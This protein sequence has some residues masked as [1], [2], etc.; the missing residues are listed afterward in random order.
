[1]AS[2]LSSGCMETIDLDDEKEEGE[3]SLED[4][5]S[6][7]EGGMGHLTS[8]YVVQNRRRA[9]PD[10][11]SWGEC[12]S[13]CVTYH[14]KSQSRRDPVKG[15]ENRHQ[16]REIGCATAKHTA[17][18]LQEK[19]DDDDLV[20]IS[21]DSDMEIVGLTGT[22]NR[23]RAKVKKKK[24]KKKDYEALTIDE[25]ISPSSVDLPIK[26][27]VKDT[28]KIYREVNPLHRSSGRSKVI[29]KSPIRRYK[30]PPIAR[31]S[32]RSSPPHNHSKSPILKRSPRKVR[33]PKRSLRRHSPVRVTK[34]P[35]KS[36]SPPSS[37]RPY[38]DRHGDVT[39]LLKK[40]KL[41]MDSISPHASESSANRGKES[42]SLKKKLS[43]MLK[44]PVSNEHARHLKRKTKVQ[45]ETVNDA[46]DED[47][48]ALLRQKALET[49]Q[50]KSSNRSSNQP[51]NLEPEKKLT[52]VNNDDQDEEALELRMIALQT[53]F[54]K[55]HE[56]RVRRGKMPT[57]TKKSIRSESPFTTS[58]LDDIPVP[59]DE[60]QLNV[61]SS[62]ICSP[63]RDSN[64]IEDM[65]LD[66]DV[67]REKEKLPYSP[68]DK[69]TENVPIDTALLGIEP[70][71]VSFINV[72]ETI[73]S[74]VFDDVP[75]A[76][77][78]TSY[79]DDA[80][81]SYQGLPGT[82]QYYEYSPSQQYSGETFHSDL[83]RKALENSHGN[84]VVCDLIDGICCQE[85]TYSSTTIMPDNSHA[86]PGSKNLASSPILLDNTFVPS[87]QIV[88]QLSNNS[89]IDTDSTFRNDTSAYKVQRDSRY[90]ITDAPTAIAY[91]GGHVEPMLPIT[92][93]DLSKN[94]TDS[95]SCL[96]DD[97]RNLPATE[98]SREPLYMQNVPDVT[99]DANKIPTLINRTLVPVPI[100]KS[101]K[102]L[103]Q[104]LNKRETPH[105]AEPA[106]K[107]AA[108]QP[109]AVTTVNIGSSSV[110]KPIKLQVA[111]KSTLML[112][113]PTTFDS[114]TNESLDI[115]EDQRNLLEKNHKAVEPAKHPDIVDAANN[116][117]A[118]AQSKKRKSVKKNGRKSLDTAPRLLDNEKS[119]CSDINVNRDTN[120][121]DMSTLDQQTAT[122]SDQSKSNDNTDVQEN[123]IKTKELSILQNTTDTQ[124]SVNSDPVTIEKRDVE[125]NSHATSAE[126]LQQEEQIEF[127]CLS[128]NP[129]PENFNPGAGD[130]TNV[131][132]TN[133]R[134]QSIEEDEDELRAILLASLKRTKSTASDTISPSIAPVV[135]NSAATNIQT[136]ALSDTTIPSVAPVVAN[137]ATTNVQTPPLKAMASTVASMA[138]ATGTASNNA[139]LLPSKPSL[140]SSETVKKKINNLCISVQNTRKRSSS[141]D[142]AKS[143]PKKIPKKALTSTKVVNNAKKYQNM[144]VQRRLNLRKLDNS[145]KSNVSPTSK[146]SSSDTQ[147]FVISLGSDSTDSE[148]EAER[149]QPIPIVEKQ[150]MS[151]DTST[152]FEKNLS[153][154]LREVRTEQ[155]QSAAAAKSS[156]SQATKRDVPQTNNGSS[157]MHTPLAVRHLPASQQE[158]YRRL[159]R[160]ILEREKLKLQ[161]KVASSNNGSSSSS[162]SSSSSNN[163]NK[164][165]NTNVATSPVKSLP[166][167][168]KKAHVK[169]NQGK[170]K[171]PEKNSQELS[172]EVER[173][174]DDT[175]EDTSESNDTS[176]DKKLLMN[177]K[178]TTPTH[179][180]AKNS[181]KAI[182]NDLSIRITNVSSLSHGDRTV[183]N[184]HETQS[185]KEQHRP[186]LRTLSTDE[187]N[188]KY[189]QVVLKTDTIERVVIINDK[190]VSQHDTIAS[191]SQ[192]DNLVEPNVSTEILNETNNVNNDISNISDFSN[193]STVKLKNSA[194]LRV[195]QHE[196]MMETTMTLSQYKAERQREINR[197]ILITSIESNDNSNDS[198][199]S[200]SI[201][202]GNG[203]D[204]WDALKRDVKA[205]LDSLASLSEVERQRYLRETEHKL[206]ARR[207]TVLD[208]LAEMSGNL[209]KWDME[210]DVQSALAN[211]VRKLKEQ[212]KVAEEKLQ[213]QRD[214]ISSM[215]PKVSVVRQ[216]IKTGRHECFKLSRICSTLGN[217]LMG[218]SYKLPE[219][220]AQ[221][222]SDKLK[223]VANHTRQFTKKKR[224]QTI[225]ISENSY[226]SLNSSSLQETSELSKNTSTEEISS[227]QQQSMND[228]AVINK[229]RSKSDISCAQSN[230]DKSSCTMPET[231]LNFSQ[232]VS[233]QLTQE[234][235]EK[236]S[237]SILEHC[238][239]EQVMPFNQNN[240]SSSKP[241]QY[242]SNSI[243][244]NKHREGNETNESDLAAFSKLESSKTGTLNQEYNEQNNRK[245]ALQLQSPSS[246]PLPLSLPSSSPL[247]TTTTTTTTT[248][249]M[250]TKTAVAPYVSILMH[251]KNPRNINPHGILCPY[252][253]MGICRDE[254]CQYIHQSRNQT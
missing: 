19:N 91:I 48:L 223:E 164:L 31:P 163:N 88:E 52:V 153:K 103:Q 63:S 35:L 171:T 148:S 42:S 215:G 251:L 70:S 178:C 125:R 203:N 71:D 224:L 177:S 244:Q 60:Q 80:Y 102:Q 75:D 37:T 61:A 218:K 154:F 5:S 25:L 108:M 217:Q 128:T 77:S 119:L 118:P 187:I 21:S 132:S 83:N 144:I 172:T 236:T 124:E 97:N 134:R 115:D 33:S 190:S 2:D 158:E 50:K 15:K 56:N 185:T 248:T 89:T 238:N 29:S 202:D 176:T 20:P 227:L 173:K 90:S 216:K 129:I 76:N 45:V 26:E 22:S 79:C 113:A 254:D 9:C 209:R 59:D 68:T 49:K 93:D 67:E 95:L 107:S 186:A 207:Y 169:Q 62:P 74:P 159:K 147:R 179:Q 145:A 157:N 162:S 141:V 38:V 10:C 72:N 14:P 106:F 249:T 174:S 146:I 237:A 235:R 197:D 253:M 1:M 85:G 3:I 104:Y 196:D 204:I 100:L 149:N 245:A 122:K 84:G 151:Q 192:N 6:S 12:A 54:T 86:L 250:T 201:A 233:Y 32:C 98:T 17:T 69:I 92:T 53:A 198:R 160:E 212:L 30:S 184:S 166:L 189:V 18:T 65:D 81:L 194:N 246:S 127:H 28:L 242:Q 36:T 46:D 156:S 137:S 183:E 131:T 64:H 40:V 210:K 96:T 55:N 165:L 135:V 43:N 66:T 94:D 39:R 109:V 44:R 231:L 182:P 27:F 117:A 206:V 82:S 221:L 57:K 168:E 152:D 226:S 180:Q 167:C 195:N 188:R 142:A 234:K 240:T 200:D 213:Q 133:N 193:A 121:V 58:Y 219:A 123:L 252:E 16:V 78:V 87:Q 229:A 99:K 136:P 34:R 140:I 225:D 170:I 138:N 143:L 105:P 116:K 175:A 155:E 41:S 47:D 110:F 181:K 7:E 24:R 4:V 101:N 111:K 126:Y 241:K 23:S 161:R 191:V 139:P 150:Q 112:S 211:E 120:I 220:V 205:E 208:H 243:E 214:V 114:S 51:T 199:K 130:S 232:T 13:W 230:Q 239:E 228:A 222:L 11:K 73:D 247:L 8:S